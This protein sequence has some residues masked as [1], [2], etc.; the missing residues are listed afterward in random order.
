MVR[1]ERSRWLLFR[2]DPTE[3]RRRS[4]PQERP[5][6]WISCSLYISNYLVRSKGGHRFDASLIHSRDHISRPPSP[7]TTP[8]HTTS[9]TAGRSS[10]TAYL[11]GAGVLPQLS[12]AS[13]HGYKNRF[14]EINFCRG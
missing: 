12:M 11:A 6:P 3:P 14:Y 1:Q 13:V 4:Q 9:L 2:S 10:S 5:P 8:F 7:S